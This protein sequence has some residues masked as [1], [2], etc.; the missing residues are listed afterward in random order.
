[1][2]LVL[3]VE[4]DDETLTSG[5]DSFVRNHGWTEES[6][7]T[8]LEFATLVIRKFLRQSIQNYNVEVA[9]GQAAKIAFDASTV[10]LDTLVTT[11]SKVDEVQPE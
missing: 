3:R 5:L 8:Q 11:L 1:M 7:E 4:G 10:V 9:R 2:A 6:P